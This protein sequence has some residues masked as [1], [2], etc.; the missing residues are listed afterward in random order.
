MQ[1]RAHDISIQIDPLVIWSPDTAF[2]AKEYSLLAVVMVVEFWR[3]DV[4]VVTFT[5]IVSWTV[6]VLIG[7]CLTFLP[8]VRLS[9]DSGDVVVLSNAGEIPSP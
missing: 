2:A 1:A 3:A 4:K 7:D 9:D 5:K 6:E 8:S